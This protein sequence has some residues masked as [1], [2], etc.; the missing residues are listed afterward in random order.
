MDDPAA[1]TDTPLLGRLRDPRS[2]WFIALGGAVLCAGSLTGGLSLE[3]WRQ[4]AR[5]QGLD[6]MPTN[7]EPWWT[8]FQHY[9][10]RTDHADLYREAGLMQWWQNDAVQL[11]FFRP[12]SVMTHQLDYWLWPDALVLHHAQSLVWYALLLA[13]VGSLYQRWMPHAWVAG[14]ALWAFAFD[15]AHATT[16]AWLANRNALVAMTVAMLAL[17]AHVRF[18]EGAA[19]GLPV[20]VALYT[21]ALLCGESAVA[22]LPWLFA[23]QITQEGSW[24]DRL[25]PLAPYAVVTALWRVAYDLAGF[26]AK[27]TLLYVDPGADPLQFVGA[28]LTRVPVMLGGLLT[29]VPIE[30]WIA[31]P[32]AVQLG[33]AAAGAAVL[34][35]F[36]LLVHR[37]LKDDA[38]A[39]FLLLG[40]VLSAIPFAAAPPAGRLLLWAGLGM[41]PLIAKL[42]FKIRCEEAEGAET[43]RLDSVMIRLLVLAHLLIAPGM[44]VGRAADADERLQTMERY[45]DQAPAD[46]AAPSRTWVWI[47]GHELFAYYVPVINAVNGRPCPMRTVILA[48]SAPD[49]EVTQ[50]D[51]NTL[52]IHAEQGMLAGKL[53]RVYWSPEHAFAAGSQF[54]T[55][56]FRATVEATTD[57]GRPRTVRFEFTDALSSDRFYFVTWEEG[58]PAPWTPDE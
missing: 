40:M 29:Q 20:G 34:L 38:I 16:V 19:W 13:V 21:T 1:A 44:L 11:H 37:Q 28:V 39:R 35:L 56:D 42:L 43:W 49:A 5:M 32:Q 48:P 10:G 36:I 6:V 55:P 57:D 41:A 4:R 14:V 15:D 30:P 31:M 27:G 52:R 58:V 51:P 53:G 26:G 12:L 50:V 54:T 33:T 47:S 18:K 45:A 3:D 25:L 2:L 46:D 8:F 9:P 22:L 17:H 7:G 23:W 24:R